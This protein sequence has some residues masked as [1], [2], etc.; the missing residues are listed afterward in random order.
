MDAT[1]DPLFWMRRAKAFVGF[2]DD[3][4]ATLALAF[5]VR[6][7]KSGTVLFK[8]GAAAPSFFIIME[9]EV[10]LLKEL[11]NGHRQ[12]LGMARKDAIL[13]QVSLVDCGRRHTS[14]MAE[15]DCVVLECQRDHFER[16][17][18]ANNSFAY[19]LLDFVVTDLSRRLREA[20][21][22]LDT[23]LSDPGETVANLYD[24]MVNVGKRIHESGEFFTPIPHKGTRLRG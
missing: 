13:G 19:K 17:F 18:R 7:F 9:G 20:N 16:L 3:E 23:L 8:E 12:K 14:A 4:R 6:P 15:T 1:R 22:S 10:A 24:K 11:S 5:S 21:A 2:T